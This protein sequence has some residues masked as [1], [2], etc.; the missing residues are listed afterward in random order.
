MM[1]IKY[2]VSADGLILVDHLDLSA[3]L[4]LL[5]R[6][7]G[8]SHVPIKRKMKEKRRDDDDVYSMVDNICI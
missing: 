1:M 8:R 6:K 2:G 3:V 4:V 5:R 7:R